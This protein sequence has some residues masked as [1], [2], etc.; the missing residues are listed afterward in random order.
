LAK[1]HRGA[2]AGLLRHDVPSSQR[3]GRGG[4]AGL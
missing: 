4:A 3:C 1:P 2:A